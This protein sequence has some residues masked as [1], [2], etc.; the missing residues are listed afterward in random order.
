MRV[1]ADPATIPARLRELLIEG[2]LTP[3][4]AYAPW[5]SPLWHASELGRMATYGAPGGPGAAAVHLTYLLVLT[6]VGYAFAR[7]TFTQRLAK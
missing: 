5:I 2:R 4:L 3:F 6:V 1:G 7:R